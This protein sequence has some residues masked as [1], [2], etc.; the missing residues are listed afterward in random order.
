M[1]L[2][3]TNQVKADCFALLFQH[4]KVFTEHINL[5]IQPERIYIQSMDTS[6]VS[7]V[8]VVLPKEWFDEYELKS[9]ESITLGISSSL[10]FRVLNARDKTQNITLDYSKTEADKLNI[11]FTGDNKQEFDKHF[12][13][14]LID[15]D[16]EIMEIPTIEYQAELTLG[17]QNFANIINQLKMFG[18]NLD[19]KCSEKEIMLC[20]SSLEQGKMYVEIEIDDLSSF[21]IDENETIQSSFSLNF[22]HNIGLYNKLSKEIEIKISNSYPLKMI[23]KLPMSEDAQMIF[24]LAPKINEDD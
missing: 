24:Y 12:E 6:H 2:S 9:Q 1:N 16:S 11:H 23:Y 8:E 22:M 19:F 20:S 14:S 5:M 7:I 3:I 13:L 4:M 15:I 18:D 21:A 17:S 10:L